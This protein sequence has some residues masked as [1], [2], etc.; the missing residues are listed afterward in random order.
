MSRPPSRDRFYVRVRIARGPGEPA[1][2][3]HVAV[4]TEVPTRCLQV[5][6]GSTDTLGRPNAVSGTVLVPTSAWSG[7]G[8]RPVLSYG[9]GV[10]GLGRDSAPSHLLREGTEAEL[11]LIERALALGWVVVASD[12][13]GL[14]MPGPHTYGAGSAGGHAMLDIARAA[15]HL[16]PELTPTSPVLL[17]GYSEGGRNAAWAAELQPTYA[18]ELALVG[19]AAGGVPSD[20]YETAK[21]IDGGPYSGLNL[22]VLIGLAR[23]YDDPQLWAILSAAGRVTAN[24]AAHLD[25]VG[26]VLGHPE[27]LATHTTRSE[28]WDDPTWR[29]V[30]ATECAGGRAPAVPAYLYHATDDDIVPSR[31]GRDL[32]HN[33][34]RRGAEVT[35]V[36]VTAPD[37]LAGG[38]LGADD[39]VTW[40][41]QRLGD[42]GTA[43]TSSTRQT[44]STRS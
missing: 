34:Q 7:P 15:I 39:A 19:L 42:H 16:V 31:L 6:H 28:P 20:L 25:V 14:G 41:A 9:V 2:A 10:H 35:W 8:P 43:L 4:R 38:H 13:E 32:A 21:A 3:R 12:G 37:H 29:R 24:L 11:P 23:A 1:R 26:L 18:P 33:W 27:P 36:D 40:L 44:E 5:V 22:A 17:W 30:L